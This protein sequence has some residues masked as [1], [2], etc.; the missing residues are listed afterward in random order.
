MAKVI[1]FHTRALPSEGVGALVAL[2]MLDAAAAVVSQTATRVTAGFTPARA[3]AEPKPP[4]RVAIFTGSFDPPTTYH[5][6]VARMLR[7]RG[8]DEVIVRPNGP[9]ANHRETEHAA[10][11]QDRKSTRL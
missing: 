8:F 9:R 11:I 3:P 10:P 5:R 2:P 4:R 1:E 7:G 6:R